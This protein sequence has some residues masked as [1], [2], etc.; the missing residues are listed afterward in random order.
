MWSIYYNKNIIALLLT[1][2]QLYHGRK[3]DKE[4]F[5]GETAG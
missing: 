4:G 1:A 3:L 2:L 5:V